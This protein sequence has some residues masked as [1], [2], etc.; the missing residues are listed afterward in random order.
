MRSPG[1]TYTKPKRQETHLEE[2]QHSAQTMQNGCLV[3]L[4]KE[5]GCDP[6]SLAPRPSQGLLPMAPCVLAPWIHGVT[7]VR[8]HPLQLALSAEALVHHSLA[9]AP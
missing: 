5:G 6:Q 7:P 3:S 2:T 9:A 8:T 1:P 4:Q